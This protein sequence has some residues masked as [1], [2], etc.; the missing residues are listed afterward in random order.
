MK[1]SILFF[2]LLTATVG[3]RAQAEPDFDAIAE[4]IVN[5]SLQQ[6][7]IEMIQSLAD[8]PLIFGSSMQ[9]KEITMNLLTNAWHP[10]RHSEQEHNQIRINLSHDLKNVFLVVQD[11]GIGMAPAEVKRVFQPFYRVDN[12]EA[13]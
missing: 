10:V 3:I 12:D 1:K 6:D 7:G 11:N 5:H 2:V 9:I 8:T 13:C 4:N